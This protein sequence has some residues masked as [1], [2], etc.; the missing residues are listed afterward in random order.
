VHRFVFRNGRVVVV[1][2][3]N[4]DQLLR[5]DFSRNGLRAS[6]LPCLHHINERSDRT[7]T[8]RARYFPA[9]VALQECGRVGTPS[10]PGQHTRRGPPTL[11]GPQEFP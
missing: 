9:A 6:R 11:W 7:P 3:V 4:S 2:V 5:R 1:G 8:G 10:Q